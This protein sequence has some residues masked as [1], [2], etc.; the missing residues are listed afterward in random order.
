MVR[1]SKLDRSGVST[2]RP[3]AWL[4]W[5]PPALT[6]VVAIALY[7]YTL[8]L[9]LFRDAMVMLRWMDDRSVAQLWI[10]ARGFPYYRPL[11]WMFLKAFQFGPGQFHKAGMHVQNVALHAL[12]GALVSLLAWRLWDGRGRALFALLSG[13]IFVSYPFSYEV[14]PVVGPIFQLVVTGLMLG[15]TLLYWESRM[16]GSRGLGVASVALGLACPFASEYGV[17]LGLLLL[18]VE[19]L[20]SRRGSFRFSYRP[21]IYLGGAAVYLLIWFLVPKSRGGQGLPLFS[22]EMLGQKSAYFLQGLVFPVAPLVRPVAG[23]G[24]TS[25]YGVVFAVA[26]MTLG[27]LA[28]LFRH[29]HR[30]RAMAFSLAWFAIGVLPLWPTL[31]LDY[32]L[33]GPRLF[34][35]A[36]VGI[37][38]LWAGLVTSLATRLRPIW[39]GRF[40]GAALALAILAGNVTFLAGMQHVLTTGGDI[41]AEVVAVATAHEDTTPLLFVNF[42]SW[43]SLKAYRFPLGW[44]GISILPGYSDVADLIYTNTGR[45]MD[46]RY[47]VSTSI[48]K[49]WPLSERFYSTPIGLA[50]LAL[51]LRGAEKVYVIQ[52]GPAGLRLTESGRVGVSLPSSVPQ[53]IFSNH[54]FVRLAGPLSQAGG[55]ELIVR[56]EWWCDAAM[57]ED[58]TVFLHVYGEGGQLV[59]QADGSPLLG[60]YPAWLWEEGEIVHD[61]RYVPLPA[62]LPAGRYTVGV[63]MY[64]VGSS[65]RLDAADAEGH[66]LPDDVAIL[67][68]F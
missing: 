43:L 2:R 16:R 60:L 14:V 19:W 66:P 65:V 41:V 22:L 36:S 26:V 15:A 29:A 58:V 63:G 33:N 51:E 17:T 3:G 1:R 23:D 62:D 50:E 25:G 24:P 21:L 42:P 44:E 9:P 45:Q 31:D 68:D 28:I 30:G 5:L 59:G 38:M 20:E 61:V 13:L 40:A 67:G 64:Q 32:V 11:A 34:Y 35:V 52:N 56:L 53:A 18:A 6:A 37:A 48:W 46:A 54:V 4:Q 8:R 12:D 7:A 49:D 55:E 39:I 47:A 57:E 10:D 27:L